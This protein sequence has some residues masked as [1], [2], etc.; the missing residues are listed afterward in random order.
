[1]RAGHPRGCTL[2]PFR[3]KARA[4][5][6]SFRD[7][8]LIATDP[9]GDAGASA[10]YIAELPR[11]TLFTIRASVAVVITETRVAPL[12]ADRTK[13]NARCSC[14]EIVVDQAQVCTTV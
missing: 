9:A 7:A 12:C 10:R 1:M 2:Q 4:V 11:L 13:L 14:V 6:Q 8:S 5:A 3:R